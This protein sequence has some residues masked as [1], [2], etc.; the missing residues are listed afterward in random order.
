MV[1]YDLCISLIEYCSVMED[2]RSV[3]ILTGGTSRRMGQ[4]KAALDFGGESLLEFVVGLIP[5]G[6]KIVVVG[7]TTDIP[8]TYVR[9]EPVGGGPVA[10][11]HAAL[12]HVPS[13]SFRV[14]AVDTPFGLPWLFEQQLPPGS[15]ALIP[16]DSQ[17]RPH[18][19]CAEYLT[20]GVAQAIHNLG[21]PRNASMNELV[22]KFTNVEYVDDPHT[23][24]LMS[25]EVLLDINTP[26]DL[27][28]AHA[29]RDR[30][31]AESKWGD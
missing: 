25:A 23:E 26:E 3:V 28:R 4:D 17:G 10:A 22:S 20:S 15:E 5:T 7:E 2:S 6:N 27:M 30:V 24:T 12:M 1:F 14:I 31:W 16:R 29:I 13:A 21:D 19:L 8:A 11:L 9:E 18:Y